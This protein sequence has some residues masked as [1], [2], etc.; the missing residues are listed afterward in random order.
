MASL[1]HEVWEESVDGMV[2][3][4]C[5]R[6]GPRG[7]GCRSF[8]APGARLLATFEAGSHFEAMAIYHRLLGREAYTSDYETDH[9]PYPEE[10]L[11]EQRGRPPG[12]VGRPPS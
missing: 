8:L 1:V 12:Q 10:W 4:T 3:H 2:L 9:E 5:C 11:E 6:A 7:D